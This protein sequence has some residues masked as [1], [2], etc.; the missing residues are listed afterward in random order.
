MSAPVTLPD[1]IVAEAVW[2]QDGRLKDQKARQILN[3]ARQVFMAAGY[4]AASMSEIA[5]IAGVSKGTLYVY[6]ESKEALFDALIRDAKREHAERGVGIDAADG[7]LAGAMTRFGTRLVVALCAP[8][9]LAHTRMVISVAGKQPHL[10]LRFYEAGFCEGRE[11]I[12][13][14]LAQQVEAGRLAIADT[15]IAATQFI[16]LCIADFARSALLGGAAH[17]DR[18]L[19]E[20]RVAAG[21]G[22]FLKAYAV[23]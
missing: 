15:R 10:G 21:V 12:S 19:V 3:G 22:I 1:P 4:D 23:A 13:A 6:F 9:S 11:K 18:A 5:R 8:S 7:D 16:D 2:R 17:E 20:K 14:W